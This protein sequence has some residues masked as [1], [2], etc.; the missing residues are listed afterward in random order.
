MNKH[1]KKTFLNMFCIRELLTYLMEFWRHW[2][3]LKLKLMNISVKIFIA[4]MPIQ[5]DY[6][7]RKRKYSKFKCK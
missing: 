3:R 6:I 1:Y 7:S 5:P 4:L 2:Q